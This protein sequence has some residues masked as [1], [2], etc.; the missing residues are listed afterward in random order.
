MF[1][2]K[3]NYFL[4]SHSPI[5]HLKIHKGRGTFFERRGNSL[6]QA[7]VEGVHIKRTRGE[8]VKHWKFRANVLFEWP[9]IYHVVWVTYENPVDD[10]MD[11]YYDVINFISKQLHFKKA[12]SSQFCWHHQ[13][14]NHVYLNN[15]LRP[16]NYQNN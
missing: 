7:C 6:K 13:N 3:N 8:G 12:W 9:H 15:L 16:K 4:S 2:K 11:K 14:Y 5:F 1:F 10:I